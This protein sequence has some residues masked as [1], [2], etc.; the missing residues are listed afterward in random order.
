MPRMLRDF[1]CL[2]SIMIDSS[3]SFTLV[4]FNIVLV[5]FFTLRDTNKKYELMLVRRATASV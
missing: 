4:P 1:F 5:F 2:H 3:T